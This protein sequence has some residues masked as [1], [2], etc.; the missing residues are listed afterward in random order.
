[1][2]KLR[3]LVLT[4]GSLVDAGA[5][6]FSHVL[7]YKRETG[8]ETPEQVAKA[9]TASANAAVDEAMAL[10]AKR[11][12]EAAAQAGAILKRSPEIYDAYHVR[13]AGER[14]EAPVRKVE[15]SRS[16]IER[17]LAEGQAKLAALAKAAAPKVDEPALAE[18]KGRLRGIFDKPRSRKDAQV[19][20][21]RTELAELLGTAE[22]RAAVYDMAVIGH[23]AAAT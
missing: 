20:E 12:P 6:Q 4:E 15:D 11:T 23:L 18:V 13:M 9:L 22:G 21:A 19:A 2:A 8:M 17:S 1:M 10:L 5:N 3:K 14:Y 7:L 16:S